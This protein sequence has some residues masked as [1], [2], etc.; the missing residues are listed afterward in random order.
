MMT[1]TTTGRQLID[2][3][4]VT[5]PTVAITVT[6]TEDPIPWDGDGPDPSEPTTETRPGYRACCG[7]HRNFPHA[8]GCAR[9]GGAR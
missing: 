2:A 9:K 6:R 5:R 7:T 3:L 4:K 8:V 1:K